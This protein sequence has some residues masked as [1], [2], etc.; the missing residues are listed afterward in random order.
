[1]Q[2]VCS[3]EDCYTGTVRQERGKTVQEIVVRILNVI[4]FL[5]I[6]VQ[7]A[8]SSVHCTG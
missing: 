3:T 1:M 5:V 4:I 7:C 6:S 2:N 8:V